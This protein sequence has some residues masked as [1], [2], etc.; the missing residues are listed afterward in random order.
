[1]STAPY[2]W[3]PQYTHHARSPRLALV[4]RD[5]KKHPLEVLGFLVGAIAAAAEH[6]QDGTFRAGPGHTAIEVFEAA[7]GWNRKR[8]LAA[9]LLAHGLLVEV[10]GGLRL[11]RWE[12]EQAPFIARLE[13]ERTRKETARAAKRGQ[14]EAQDDQGQAQDGPPPVRGLSA[15]AP[16]TVRALDV[17][18][19]REGEEKNSNSMGAG[20]PGS[21]L[22]LPGTVPGT[23]ADAAQD[24]P[25]PVRGL[26]ADAP[27]TPATPAPL[28]LVP[29]QPQAPTKASKRADLTGLEAAVF[30]AWVE[31]WSLGPAY[32]M[33]PD[34]R[35]VIAARVKEGFTEA[36][37]VDA[38]K[39]SKLDP[40]PERPQHNDLAQLLKPSNVPKFAEW[41]RSGAPSVR[42]TFDPRKGFVPVASQKHAY[43]K[44]LPGEP[45]RLEDM[46]RL[47]PEE[48][49]PP[50]PPVPP[51]NPSSL[52]G[53]AP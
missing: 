46:P 43:S 48:A 1:M 44:P 29:S 27:R 6:Y 41:H 31:T 4:A 26:S 21:G 13:R 11:E 38:V 12:A 42:P 16:R 40:W 9:A 15:D 3:L 22:D 49:E 45:T 2:Q 24:I 37:L 47:F 35:R 25:R 50:R 8:S 30:A 33:T 51:T 32:R 36:D 7:V 5:L 10:E 20:A 39:G 52:A 23:S 14:D 34:R 28:T 53:G 18:G 17:D 19:K